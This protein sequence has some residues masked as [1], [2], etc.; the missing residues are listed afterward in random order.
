MLAGKA[1]GG[2]RNK[3][4]AIY[5][6]LRPGMHAVYRSVSNSLLFSIRL[7]SSV[8]SLQIFTC[9]KSRC[10]ERNTYVS[11]HGCIRSIR[12]TN[13]TQTDYLIVLS[14]HK[15]HGNFL[16]WCSIGWIYHDIKIRPESSSL[17]V[18]V[19]GPSRTNSQF[20]QN[21]VYKWGFVSTLGNGK[22]RSGSFWCP[23]IPP[24]FSPNSG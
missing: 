12:A 3:E 8:A 24:N 21:C 7:H 4:K 22:G 5:L 15:L 11:F 14:Y 23:L 13:H 1:P 10:R 16:F 2:E 20:S 6:Q 9:F 17:R 18:R 19:G